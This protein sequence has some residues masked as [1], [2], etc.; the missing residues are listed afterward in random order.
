MDRSVKRWL[1]FGG[2]GVA[3]AAASCVVCAASGAVFWFAGTGM[4]ADQVA[5]DLQRN[6]VIQEHIGT[7]Q[8][9]K[10]D[11]TA[12]PQ[13]TGPEVNPYRLRGTRGRG[14][15][16]VSTH[17]VSGDVE[18]VDSGTLYMDGGGAYDLFP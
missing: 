16:V 9:C 11:V 15:V 14:V 4:L 7:I 18:V 5:A 2:A 10:V 6:P 13:H 17:S 3:L 1:V 12:A 8:S